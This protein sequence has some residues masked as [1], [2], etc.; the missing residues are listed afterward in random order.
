[1]VGLVDTRKAR[2]MFEAGYTNVYAISKA[3]PVD[4]MKALQ[5]TLFTSSQQYSAALT[6]ELVQGKQQPSGL[7]AAN[8]SG[9][10][11]LTGAQEIIQAAKTVMKRRYLEKAR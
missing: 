4:I 2:A 10:A 11:T 5:R 6:S 1:M 3:K 9:L 8:Q 7:S